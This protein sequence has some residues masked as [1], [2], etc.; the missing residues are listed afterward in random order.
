MP[1]KVSIRLDVEILKEIKELDLNLS[2]T[3]R[4]AL[5]DEIMKKRKEELKKNMD[6]ARDL[7]GSEDIDFFTR[8]LGA[9]R[10]EK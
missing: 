10:D 6:K 8:A 9:T 3:F 4:K 2:E 5:L 1:H 7:L